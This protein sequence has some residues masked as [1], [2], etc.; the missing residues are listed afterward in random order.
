MAGSSQFSCEAVDDDGDGEGPSTVQIGARKYPP[1]PDIFQTAELP[2]PTERPLKVYAFDPSA[3]RFVGNHMTVSVRYEKL[4]PGPVGSRF[5]VV[6]YDGGNKT[7]YKA[8][9]LD[10]PKLLIRG[11]LPPSETDPRFHQQMVYAVASETLQRFEY[12]L[13]RR[14]RWRGVRRSKSAE[15]KPVGSSECLHLYP[16][17]MCQA[18]AFYSPEAHGILF[19]YFAARR[20]EQGRNLPGQ[21]VF[22]CLSH[23]IIVHEVTHAVLD[24]IRGFFMEPTNVDVAAFHEAFADL[25]ALFLHFTHK[26]ALLDTLQKT[27]GRL[28][29]FKLK[30]DVDPDDDPQGP[31]FQAQ[32]SA[33]NPLIALAMQFGEASGKR[34]GLRSALGTRPNSNDIRKLTEPHDRGSILVAAVFDAYFTIYT[35][36]TFELFRIFRA[37][38]GSIT[39]SDI[40]IPLANRLAA[41]ASRTA[42]DFFLICAR[43]LDY[44]PPVDITFGDFLRAVM[45]AH[46]D[47]QP[48]D[49]DGVRDALMQ[50]FRLRGIFA[51][52]A[53][54]FSE[55]ALFW[56]KVARGGK[57]PP[58]KGLVFGDPNGLSPLEKN[59]NGEVL[60]AYAKAN[61]HLL[62]FDRDAG[63]IS[64]PSFH[65]M[66]HTSKDGSLFV[67]MVVELVQTVRVPFDDGGGSGTFPLRNGATLLIAQDPVSENVKPDERARIRFVIP[68]RHTPEREEQVRNFFLSSGRAISQK[69]EADPAAKLDSDDARFQIDFGLLHAGI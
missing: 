11:G 1:L 14:V 33:D 59:K 23:D 45:T 20:T 52:D 9:D 18:N 40:P 30:P 63:K 8:V 60:R 37:G 36:R 38:G 46:L 32:L 41:E 67:N 69:I 58:V 16:H 44:C 66:F 55:D 22:T 68:K 27:G 43:A 34:G 35:R 13:G 24:G 31:A 25:A 50:A 7:F 62:G 12:A 47:L 48:D 15:R 19:G 26:E 57:L 65:P 4:S 56:P 21:T 28:F 39:K 49:P 51:D 5:A 6:D 10:D 61:A 53:T 42:D 54:S 17:A 29:D 2:F 3:G 64:A